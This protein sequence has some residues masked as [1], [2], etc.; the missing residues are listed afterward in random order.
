MKASLDRAYAD[1][2]WSPDGIISE[3]ALENDM[4]VMIKT[5]IFKGTYTYDG[6]VDMQFVKKANEATAK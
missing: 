6:L 2:L 4:N 5:G 3:K 1:S